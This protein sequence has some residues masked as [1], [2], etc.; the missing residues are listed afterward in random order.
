M[1]YITFLQLL[2]V[3]YQRVVIENR[4]WPRGAVIAALHYSQLPNQWQSFMFPLNMLWL[5]SLLNDFR[6]CIIGKQL[7]NLNI[8]GTVRWSHW[9][10]RDGLELRT[11]KVKPTCCVK[12]MW[13]YNIHPLMLGALDHDGRIMLSLGIYTLISWIH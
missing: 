12:F 4:N 10:F 6:K 2:H 5:S 3:Q 11:T 1:F 7:S 9:H 13:I 8:F